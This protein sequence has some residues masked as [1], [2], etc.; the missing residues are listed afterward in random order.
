MYKVKASS[1]THGLK[2]PYG[3]D[4]P[5]RIPEDIRV[6][7]TNILYE[8]VNQLYPTGRAFY[9]G[10]NGVFERLHLGIN[11][12]FIRLINQGKLTID[13]VYPDT[14]NFNEQDA[15]LWE[16]RLGLLTNPVIPI[17]ERRKA[18]QR[19][20]AY[21]ANIRARAH[22]LFIQS[23]LQAAG[24]EVYLHENGFLENGQIVYKTPDQIA[25]TAPEN[26]QHGEPTQHGAG[27][28]HGT[29]NFE[30]VA[31]QINIDESYSVGGDQNL[32]ATFFIGGPT[33]GDATNLL[34]SREEEFRELV[35][36]LKPAH[37]VAF[38]FINFI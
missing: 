27:Q 9:G 20:I 17:K 18:I 15:T 25:A 23:Q 35:L 32:W 37:S 3:L 8:L 26:T 28:Q 29:L 12:S 30:V 16:Y 22:P 34:A 14:I 10:E 36:K 24:F 7:F 21:P 1:T 2:T 38:L 31:N 11:V 33:L 4:T 19:K 5:H 6:S 13:K